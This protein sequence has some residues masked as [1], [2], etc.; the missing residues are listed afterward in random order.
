MLNNQN[1]L[2]DNPEMNSLVESV[3]HG[4]KYVLNHEENL[5]DHDLFNNLL[6]VFIEFQRIDSTKIVFYKFRIFQK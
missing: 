1:F 5:V 2:H 6:Q 3:R 4:L